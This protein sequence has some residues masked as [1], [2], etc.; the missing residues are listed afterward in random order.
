MEEKKIIYR[1]EDH[2]NRSKECLLGTHACLQEVID[3]L[4]NTGLALND[5]TLT[6]LFNGGAN[7][8]SETEKSI[9][10][11][12]GKFK[13]SVAKDMYEQ[14][15]QMLLSQIDKACANATDAL[16]YQLTMHTTRYFAFDYFV[17]KKLK[18]ELVP[19]WETKIEDQ[20]TDYADTPE[21]LELLERAEKFKKEYEDFYNFLRKHGD[22]L[23]PV[24]MD[25]GI[26]NNGVL[27]VSP[28]DHAIS[29]NFYKFASLHSKKITNKN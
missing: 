7:L 23:T 11:E 15:L 26:L 5:N 13:F 14:H 17:L 12:S 20:H 18:V 9:Q 22:F 4:A 16:S 27:Y 10:E 19:G 24:T 6:D 2:I 21:K 3:T 25:A 29:I 8:K 28:F 1:N